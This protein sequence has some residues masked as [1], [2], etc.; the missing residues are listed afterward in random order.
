MQPSKRAR[1]ALAGTFEQLLLFTAAALMRTDVE[2][3]P[4]RR[5]VLA[6]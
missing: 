6:G 4:A 5:P 3:H 1:R 2:C